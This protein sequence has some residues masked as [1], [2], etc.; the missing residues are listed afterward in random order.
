[1][2]Y[3]FAIIPALT[4]LLCWFFTQNKDKVIS[5]LPALGVATALLLL[6]TLGLDVAAYSS[7][8]TDREVWG[9]WITHAEYYEDWNEYVHQ[10]C[11]RTVGS[12][13]N[14]RT[15]TYDCS[16]VQY[17]PPYYVA[18]TSNNESIYINQES[19]EILDAKFGN[20]AFHDMRRW[21]HT[22]DGDMYRATW[23]GDEPAFTKV[24]TEYTYTN[25]VQS[26]DGVFKFEDVDP[27]GLYQYPEV[28]LWNS[29]AVLGIYHGSTEADAII[30]KYNAKSGAAK[31]VRV[32][33]LL[34]NGGI[35]DA[36]N[37][38]S[39]WKGG[40][41]NEF[42][43]CVGIN[44][45]KFSWVQHFCWSPE[46]Y[47]GNDTIGIEMRS[48]VG[49]DADLPAISIDLCDRVN[50][51]WKRKSFEEFDYLSVN[52]GSWVTIVSLILSGISA[53][54][55]NVVDFSPDYSG[56]IYRRI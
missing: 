40:N 37:Q 41:K 20:T 34:F 49:K 7:A 21:Y 3:C 53:I 29:P 38:R 19:W 23:R 5:R 15:E 33:L 18:Y 43:L 36:M 26:N 30:Q 12:G 14:Q 13:E 4:T 25:K 27:N 16:Y 28:T 45:G 1:M 10:I 42:V 8:V 31:Q 32:M 46:G 35:E 47:T 50:K 51:Y 24:F 39:L 55:V 11:T 54:V 22:D 17:H 9:G 48:W 52:T 56:R 44:Q 6:I 2:S